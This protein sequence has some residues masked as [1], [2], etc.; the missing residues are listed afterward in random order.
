[1]GIRMNYYDILAINE[2]ASDVDIKKAYFK[3]IRIYSPDK[4]PEQFK[5]IREA[6]DYLK[7]GDNRTTYK[8]IAQ[9]DS[10]YL[11][12]YQQAVDCIAAFLFSNAADIC[13]EAI[14]HQ[15]NYLVFHELL[16]KSHL[17]NEE[18]GKAVKDAENLVHMAPDS[19]EYRS[20][21]A[22]AYEERGFT[23]KAIKQYEELYLEEYRDVQFLVYYMQ[24]DKLY[25]S[26]LQR[27]IAFDIIQQCKK[28]QKNNALF[29]TNAFTTLF[30]NFAEVNSEFFK[31]DIRLLI[32][33]LEENKSGIY[34]L[35]KN[36]ES[37]LEVIFLLTDHE[38]DLFAVI[39]ELIQQ[40]KLIFNQNNTSLWKKIVFLEMKQEE[41]R[42]L[43]DKRIGDTIK[44]VLSF[45]FA[46]AE[47]NQ[48]T[49]DLSFE[50][51]NIGWEMIELN[52][53][54]SILYEMPKIKSEL[55]IVKA[56]Y[57][58]LANEMKVFIDELEKS[59]NIMYMRNKIEKKLHPK[60]GYPR[61][62]HDADFND[63]PPFFAAEEP[64]RRDNKKIGRNDPCP[65]GSGKKYKHCCGK[66]QNV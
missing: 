15:P 32:D 16:V 42:L 3:Q 53:K 21:L 30:E 54:L 7:E 50:F 57:P 66:N 4:A 49:S 56:E 52:V 6:Y 1:M 64:Y 35:E 2:T 63:D 39:P 5:K 25:Q 8:K 24:C 43:E 10:F 41:Y 33:Y 60:I 40:L 61:G 14:A 46:K 20:L 31:N 37:L 34:F 36:M 9:L 58:Y 22:Y 17:K 65:C 38:G 11:N 62:G 26:D 13:K 48:N 19:R 18:F 59:N 29:V 47:R 27:E 12:M 28:L 44:K 55:D 45:Y 23:K 51:M